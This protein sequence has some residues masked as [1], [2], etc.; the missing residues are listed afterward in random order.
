MA[1]EYAVNQADLTLIADAIRSKGETSEALVFPSEF[2]TAIAAITGGGE[3][4]LNFSVV[5]GTTQPVNPTEN[6]IWVNTDREITGWSFS[7]D[8]PS[9]PYEGM[10]WFQTGISG[11]IKFNTLQENEIQLRPIDAAQYVSGA[12]DD[13]IAKI[14]KESVWTQ[15][16]IETLYLY[17]HGVTDAETAGGS[18]TSYAKSTDGTSMGGS[19]VSPQMSFSTDHHSIYVP[20]TTGW[21]VGMIAL[22]NKIRLAGYSK[23]TCSVQNVN[24]GGGFQMIIWASVGSAIFDNVIAQKAI[25]N[26]NNSIDI[27][28]DMTGEYVIG[29]YLNSQQASGNVGFDLYELK[30]E[31]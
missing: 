19:P 7:A 12:W 30:L 8:E 22:K 9:E 3:N 25:V 23:L 16:R 1:N 29:F 26:G 24:S 17:D 10:V 14:Y 5:G 18:W 2:V 21:N 28:A 4:I 20:I 6:T 27:S 13:V 15:I 11:S 31:V